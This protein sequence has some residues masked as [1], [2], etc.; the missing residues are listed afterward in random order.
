M[1]ENRRDWDEAVRFY[2]RAVEIDTFYTSAYTGLATAYFEL[3]NYELE[4]E[5]YQAAVRIDPENPDS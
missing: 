4:V 5:N 2:S 1:A 3:G